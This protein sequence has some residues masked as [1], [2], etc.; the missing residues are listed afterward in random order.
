MVKIFDFIPLLKEVTKNL[1]RDTVT[2]QYPF[3]HVKVPDGFR[4]APEVNPELC[5]V[6]KN[7]EKECPTQCI[8]IT[9]VNPAE[10]QNY[11]LGQGKPFWFSINLSQCMFCQV[12]EESC[13]VKR[14]SSQSAITLNHERWRLAGYNLEETIEK[15]LVYQKSKEKSKTITQ[16]VESNGIN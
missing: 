3:E 13:P 15:K 5:I 6:C 10:L 14:K 7:C 9:P 16:E 12:C 8:D 1:L 2:V 11:S 4:G